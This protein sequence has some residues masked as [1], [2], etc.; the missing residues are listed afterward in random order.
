MMVFSRSFGF[1]HVALAALA[2]A[3]CAKSIDTSSTAVPNKTDVEGWL[4]DDADQNANDS[5]VATSGSGLRKG[6]PGANSGDSD[7]CNDPNN[8]CV[9]GEGDCDTNAQCV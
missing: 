1:A 3:S 9:W 5:S 4:E 7:F 6:T 8:R 2:A